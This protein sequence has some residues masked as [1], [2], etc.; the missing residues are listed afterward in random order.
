MSSEINPYEAPQ[1]PNETERLLDSQVVDIAAEKLRD[2]YIAY[3]RAVRLIGSLVILFSMLFTSIG[4]AT[5]LNITMHNGI[6]VCGIGAFIFIAGVG[7][8]RLKPWGR[9]LA[10]A[11]AIVGT[12]CF[13]YSGLITAPIL[14]LLGWNEDARFVFSREYH[15]AMH[16]TQ[17]SQRSRFSMAGAFLFIA[18]V[19]GVLLGLLFIA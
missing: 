12:I 1:A 5:L 8:Y 18:I 14:Y 19:L 17:H 13:P 7:L 10:L 9:W 2:E 4:L 6:Y 15:E 3:E 11:L 16:A